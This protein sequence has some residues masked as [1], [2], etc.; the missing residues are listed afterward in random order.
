MA[1]LAPRPHTTLWLGAH[2]TGTTYLQQMLWRSRRALERNGIGYERLEPFR[3][4]FLRPM[5]N[6]GFVGPLA[7]GALLHR[8]EVQTLIFDE[9]IPGLVQHA[10][11]RSCLYP[12]M[13]ARVDRVC[14]HFDLEPDEIV[15][16]IRDF[17]GYLPSLYCE[18]LKSNPYRP[19]AK[20]MRRCPSR[21]S[22]TELIQ[23]LHSRFPEAEL[24]VYRHE[25]L[26]GNEARLLG[27][28]T[29]LPPRRFKPP[30]GGDRP[31][32]SAAAI[33]R[34]D[35]MAA[36]GQ[37]VGPAQVWETVGA[38]PRD[39]EHP[40]FDPWTGAERARLTGCYRADL[41]KLS[42]MAHVRLLD[43]HDPEE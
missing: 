19:F 25:D 24:R 28:I 33:A 16:G 22:W 23:R 38:L 2:K 32:F 30:R 31:G 7:P 1:R 20:F 13:I 15:F 37:R 11:S 3:N 36:Q 8:G 18:T 12:E 14:A 35:E 29:N 17:A 39:A 21:P 41:D 4:R 5:L 34:L 10:L 40:G 43:F 42:Q 6:E 27:R 26:R 9:N